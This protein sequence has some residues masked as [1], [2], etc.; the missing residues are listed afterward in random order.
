LNKKTLALKL[1][2]NPRARRLIIRLLKNPHVQRAI[3]NQISR[4]IGR[5]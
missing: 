4:R 5:K 2:K 1:L 3:L